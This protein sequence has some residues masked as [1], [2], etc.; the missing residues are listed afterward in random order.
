MAHK[1]SPLKYIRGSVTQGSADAYKQEAVTTGLSGETKK[2]YRVLH[3]LLEWTIAPD[4]ADADMIQCQFTRKSQAAVVQVS[5]KSLIYAKKLQVELATSGA[6]L[7]PFI[8]REDFPH[9]DG[10]IFLIVE[11]PIYIAIDST[12]VGTLAMHYS[13]AYEEVAIAEDD[14]LNLLVSSLS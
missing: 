6:F 3:A 2:A 1:A 8:W 5:D 13:L 14:R 12:A 7:F 11:D 9:D 4:A 10:D